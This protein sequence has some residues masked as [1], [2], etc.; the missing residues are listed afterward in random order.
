MMRA[1]VALLA[2]RFNLLAIDQG[3]ADVHNYD[4]FRDDAQ[5]G[6]ALGYTGKICLTPAQAEASQSVFR[7]SEADLVWAREVLD[8]LERALAT[9]HG[10]GLIGSMFVDEAAARRARRI[11]A[12]AGVTELQ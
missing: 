1:Q 7:P 11:L 9:G 10:V 12:S 5:A 4:H 8:T 3:V 6:K 2:R